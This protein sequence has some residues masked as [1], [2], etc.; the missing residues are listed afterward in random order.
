MKSSKFIRGLRSAGLS[1]LVVAL[2]AA[3]VL[4]IGELPG[5][6]TRFDMTRQGYYS[7]SDETVELLSGLDEDV[8]LVLLAVKGSED[9]TLQG[10]LRGY[11]D[12][13]D[14]ISFRTLDPAARPE[15]AA[16][17]SEAI[18]YGN[19]VAVLAGERSRLLDYTELYVSDYSAF[20]QSGN[21]AD[22]VN[23]FCAESAITGAIDYVTNDALPTLYVLGGHGEA[24]LSE[25]VTKSLIGRGIRLESLELGEGAPIPAD[26]ACILLN[27]P[28]YDI[29][30]H[31]RQTLVAYLEAGGNMLLTTA[32]S[33][34]PLPELAAL[35]DGF[36]CALADGLVV[37]QDRD[38]YVYG[39]YDCLLPDIQSHEITAGLLEENAYV[40]VPGA[41]PITAAEEEISFTPLLCSSEAAYAATDLSTVGR[42]GDEVN[43]PFTLGAAI[44]SGDS[45]VVWFSTGFLLNET[46]TQSFGGANE[47][48]FLESVS[49]LCG[50][51]SALDIPG[52]MISAETLDIAP[53]SSLLMG[54]VFCVMIPLCFVIAGAVILIRRRRAK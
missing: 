17:Y 23:T 47:E 27:A 1:L 52:K 21:T 25:T 7:L 9:I 35:T 44:E 28:A 34:E 12:Q 45:R 32:Y 33:A 49:W 30:A 3:A 20:Y 24:A 53:E 10:L 51:G 31:E 13:S 38:H 19:S 39:Y 46:Y 40:I 11:A 43:G 15:E 48:L 14:H 29:S 2:A 54:A 6:I 26:C 50:S 5:A 36:G 22:I 18:R 4:G 16:A 42:K 8:E 41:Q 37:E